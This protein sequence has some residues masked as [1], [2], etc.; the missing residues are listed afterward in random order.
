MSAFPDPAALL[1]HG[2]PMRW[3][4][5]ILAS[6][7]DHTRA[8][9]EVRASWPLA[10]DGRVPTVAALELLAQVAAAHAALRRGEAEGRGFVVG[11]P[12]LVMDRPWLA[13][14]EVL[15]VALQVE[16]DGRIVRVAGEV[17][18][19]HERVAHGTLLVVREGGGHG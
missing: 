8:R 11:C 9:A 16:G 12:E 19:G 18:A 2:P 1:P 7:G 10:R 17:R 5:A 6:E 14:G 13:V 15:E 4:D 3:L